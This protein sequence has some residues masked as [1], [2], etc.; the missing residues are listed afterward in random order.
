MAGMDKIPS[1]YYES[2][3][4]DGAGRIRCFFRI[5]LPLIRGVFRNCIMFWT[6]GCVNF[7]TWSLMFAKSSGPSTV[8][9]AVYMYN[10][11]FGPDSSAGGMINIGAGTSAGV[12]MIVVVVL[13]YAVMNLLFPEREVEY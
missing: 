13:A 8:V 11:I 9:P 5:T 10:N 2:A 12:V 7:F 6:I 1:E 3:S 4:I